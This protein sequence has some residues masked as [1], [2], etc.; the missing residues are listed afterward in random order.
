MSTRA[1]TR[2]RECV[3]FLQWCLPRLGYR[4]RG[5]RKVRRQVCRRA[6]RRLRALDLPDLAAYR[7][8]LLRN[9]AEWS[10]LDVCCRITISRFYRDMA[11]FRTIGSTVLPAL[12]ARAAEEKRDVRCWAIGCAS[13]EEVY[14]LR[15]LWDWLITGSRSEGDFGELTLPELLK[16]NAWAVVVPVAIMLAGLLWWIESS[17]LGDQGLG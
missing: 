12:A 8:L 6:R 11:V 5:F 16:V 17:G 13:G 9:P 1:V 3:A 14:T 4:W 10:H 7:D 15:I 2:D